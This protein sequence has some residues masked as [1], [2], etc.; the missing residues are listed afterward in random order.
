MRKFVSLFGVAL[1]SVVALAPRVQA[2][3][4]TAAPAAPPAGPALTAPTVAVVD[5]QRV[6]AESQ[7]GKSIQAQ[8]ET[9]GRKIRDQIQHLD[10]ELKAAENEVRRQQVVASPEA[11]NE[12][13]QAL[14]RKQADAQRVVQDRRD[15]FNKGQQDAFNVVGDN[16]RDIVQQLAAERRI[17]LVLRKD[18]VMTIS[19]KNMDITDDVIQRLNTKLPTVTVTVAGAGAQAAATTPAQAPAPTAAKGKK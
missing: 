18:V 19:D 5:V 11:R 8:L 15:A 9:E 16:L 4:P 3:T 12:Q 2:Q 1:L 17:G 13:M 6:L 14:Q 10:D 7:A